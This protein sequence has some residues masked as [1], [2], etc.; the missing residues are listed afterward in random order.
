MKE[1]VSGLKTV[2]PGNCA[3]MGKASAALIGHKNMGFRWGKVFVNG[4]LSL[5]L[6]CWTPNCPS[7]DCF[8]Y[9]GRRN[10]KHIRL[11]NGS[12]ARCSYYTYRRDFE[13]CKAAGKDGFF[14]HLFLSC[15]RDSS[16]NRTHVV[17]NYQWKWQH[18]NRTRPLPNEFSS[19]SNQTTRGCNCK[20]KPYVRAWKC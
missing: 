3:F 18:W 6:D 11:T 19:K 15:P 13:G 17:H 8:K 5:G 9:R 2:I 12:W 7:Y 16:T 4:L 10:Q 20:W 14:D 1:Q